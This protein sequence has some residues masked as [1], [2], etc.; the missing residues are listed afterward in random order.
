MWKPREGAQT[1]NVKE[2]INLIKQRAP[3]ARILV[4]A[5]H[6]GPGSRQPDI[7]RQELRDLFGA[8]TVLDFFHVDSKPD[9]HGER[10]GIDALKRAIANVAASFT[11]N[12][13]HRAETLAG[14]ARGVAAEREPVSYR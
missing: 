13:A 3:E 10:Y 11:G 9:E 14:G 8:E 1:G 5:T 4:V 2:W 12:G 7:D 6:G